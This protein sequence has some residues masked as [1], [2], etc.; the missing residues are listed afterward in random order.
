M[1]KTLKMPFTPKQTDP[2]AGPVLAEIEALTREIQTAEL[3]RREKTERRAKL[4]TQARSYNV[5]LKTLAG[6]LDVTIGRIRQIE[7]GK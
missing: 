4:I 2:R 7:A 5:T 6:I 3:V 1:V